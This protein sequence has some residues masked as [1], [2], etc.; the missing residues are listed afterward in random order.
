MDGANVFVRLETRG[1]GTVAG[2]KAAMVTKIAIANILWQCNYLLSSG[3]D[4]R[5]A[6]SIQGRLRLRHIHS[7]L[8]S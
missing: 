8:V 3:I 4:N 6:Q 2:S 1:S 5:K 7:H